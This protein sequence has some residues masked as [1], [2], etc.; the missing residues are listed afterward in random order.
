M[1]FVDVGAHYGYH[2]LVASLVVGS[3]RVLSLEP[4]RGVFS[5]L[6]ANVAGAANVSP[7]PVAAFS[8]PATV[9]LQDFGPRCSALSTLLPSARVPPAERRGLR[10]RGG[11]YPVPAVALDDLLDEAGLVADVVKLDAEGAELAILGGMRRMLERSGPV[12]T[13][14]TGDYDGMAS[15]ATAECLDLLESHGYRAHELDAGGDLRPHR[16][17]PRYDYGNLFLLKG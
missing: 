17:R 5:L 4:G 12:V 9:V 7:L 6:A 8:G 14:E 15:P 2:S 11:A 1:V 3:G 16:R 10:L 13:L